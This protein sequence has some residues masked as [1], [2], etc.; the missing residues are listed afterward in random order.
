MDLTRKCIRKNA[1]FF[2][3]FVREGGNVSVCL[4][5]QLQER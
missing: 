5:K 4:E 1:I 3:D 2:Y